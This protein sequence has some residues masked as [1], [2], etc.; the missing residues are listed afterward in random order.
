MIAVWKLGVALES[1]M[2]MRV[3]RG[4]GDG[5]NPVTE[6]WLFGAAP[7]ATT[8]GVIVPCVPEVEKN[9]VYG[10]RPPEMANVDTA[11]LHVDGNTPWVSRYVYAPGV[12]VSSDGL[13]GG[14]TPTPS[15]HVIVTTDCSG[16][17][18]ESLTV[19]LVLSVPSVNPIAAKPEPEFAIVAGVIVALGRGGAKNAVYGGTPPVITKFDTWFTHVELR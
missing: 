14:G 19:M 6:N 16:G 11:V 15:G 7:P 2:V 3:T 9:T 13:G 4:I 18:L 5:A 10:A 12:T 8:P 17:V 1:W